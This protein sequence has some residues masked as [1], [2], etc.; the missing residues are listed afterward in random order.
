MNVKTDN[1]GKISREVY[2]KVKKAIN[3]QRQE[4]INA[5]HSLKANK[6][7]AKHMPQT[8]YSHAVNGIKMSIREIDQQLVEWK[9][10]YIR[11]NQPSLFRDIE[12]VLLDA[13]KALEAAEHYVRHYAVKQGE[14]HAAG[15][16][17]AIKSVSDRAKK[18]FE[19][20]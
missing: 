4:K 8:A 12:D 9:Q 1:K 3:A 11:S 20:K 7:L 5:L 6:E 19:N 16:L 15:V 2:R 10:E 17:N 14:G 13:A 18:I